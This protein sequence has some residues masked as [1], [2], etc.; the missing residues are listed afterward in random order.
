MKT[1]NIPLIEVLKLFIE[2]NQKLKILSKQTYYRSLDIIQEYFDNKSVGDISYEDYEAFFNYLNNEK[3]YSVNSIKKVYFLL[4]VGLNFGYKYNYNSKIDISDLCPQ[5]ITKNDKEEITY[6][7]KAEQFQLQNACLKENNIRSICI[8]ICLYTGI[9][10]GEVCGL[11]WEDINLNNGTIKINKTASRI[12]SEKKGSKTELIVSAT[13]KEATREMPIP[14]FINSKLKSFSKNK[15]YY[16]LS[17]DEKIYDPRLL[18]S[19]LERMEEKY[20]LKKYDF[21]SLRHSFAI[22]TIELGINSDILTHMLGY[23]NPAM[24]YTTYS[25]FFTIQKISLS[26]KRDIINKV[27]KYINSNEKNNL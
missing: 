23:A 5:K 21:N 14:S 2:S 19:Y 18:M 3:N 1:Y 7:T 26:E 11:K 9:K 12:K 10:V 22:K 13:E 15:N 16:I 6:L 24:I 25:D 8:L 17:Q 4:S 20:K 27:V